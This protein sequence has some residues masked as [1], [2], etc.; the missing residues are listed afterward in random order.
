M[1]EI[2][3]CK[4]GHFQFFLV[5]I[6]A[7]RDVSGISWSHSLSIPINPKA[8]KKPRYFV[9]NHLLFKKRKILERVRDV[10]TLPPSGETCR[11]RFST[12]VRA[13]TILGIKLTLNVLL[14]YCYRDRWQFFGRR[15]PGATCPTSPRSAWNHTTSIFSLSFAFHQNLTLHY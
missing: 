14:I 11:G 10:S 8:A 7:P 2:S 9:L 15:L 4:E 5:S 3:N 13:F 6:S 1:N 12:C